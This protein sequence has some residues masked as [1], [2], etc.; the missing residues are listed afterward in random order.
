MGLVVITHNAQNCTFLCFLQTLI[1]NLLRHLLRVSFIQSVLRGVHTADDIV[2]H[3]HG[4]AI[5]M[6]MYT[7]FR[8]RHPLTFSFISPWMMC[9]F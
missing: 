6:Y 8:K 2:R 1:Y 4:T 5:C 7:V 3:P 9:G